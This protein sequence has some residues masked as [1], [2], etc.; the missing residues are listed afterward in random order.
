[1]WIRMLAA[2][3]ILAGVSGVVSAPLFGAAG[4][5]PPVTARA[6]DLQGYI[7]GEIKAGRQR[8]VVPPGRYRVTP[9]NRE[10]LALRGLKDVTIIAEGVEM[11]CTET[12][13]ALTISRCTNVTV[14]GLTI[15]YDPLPFTQGRITGFAADKKA[16]DIELFEGYPP[17]ETAR[18]FKYEIFRPDTRTLRCEDRNVQ[19]IEVVDARHLR[20]STPNG[21]ASDAEQVGDL[22]VIG[23]EYAPHGSAAHAVEC[24]R[25]ANVRLENIDLF[26]SNC[27]GFLEYECEGSTYY[28]CRID[29]RSA[30]D[31]PVK[32]AEPRLRSLDADAFHSKH[33]VKGP[34][35]IECAARFQGD[36]CV[37]ICGDYHMIMESQGREL[38][39]LAKHDMNIQ[40]GD[41]VELVTYDG[42]RLPDGKAVAIEP[43]GSIREEERAF[44]G[45]QRMDANLKAARGALTKA[46]KVT[47][48]R[49]VDMAMG[50]VICSASRIGNG[51]V[52][53]NCNFGF[54]R[55]RGIL[56]KASHGEVSG[57]RIEGAEMS[58][59]LVAPEYWWL[60]AGS[61]SD[62]KI[63][64]NT[65]IGCHGI[66]ICIEATAGNGD[67]AP[68]G[69]HRNLSITGNSVQ[70]CPAPGILV[71]S[72]SGLRLENNTLELNDNRKSLPGVMRKA[73]LKELQPVVRI[74]CEQ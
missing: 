2:L 40:P 13:R 30:A 63:T 49:E 3:V 33:A 60:E 31:D 35:Y 17:A 67:I 34:A 39:V 10:H 4:P 45:R 41:P 74:N 24:S 27:F 23:A 54:N 57:N 28:R 48:D 59:I 9:H 47:L 8:I 32:R 7:D 26:A 19:K 20:L 1:M 72:T 53:K 16:C 18:N 37:N 11:I 46:F 58:A 55:S 65:I 69:A 62:L 44:L 22:I 38:R 73:G 64:G 21:R 50:G 15:D 51:F 29:R 61:S 36:D 14:R 66:P 6:F 52:V 42:R 12:T 71:C 56:I 5:V 70:N 43:A 68:A 25:S